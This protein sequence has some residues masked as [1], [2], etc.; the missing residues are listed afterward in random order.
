[1]LFFSSRGSIKPV[2]RGGKISRLYSDK[3]AKSLPRVY[4]VE[5]LSVHPRYVILYYDI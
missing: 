1:M 2:L 4:R 3:I 5:V